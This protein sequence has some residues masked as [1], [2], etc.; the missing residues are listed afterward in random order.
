MDKGRVMSRDIHAIRGRVPLLALAFGASLALAACS[1]GGASSGSAVTNAQ[2]GGGGGNSQCMTAAQDYATFLAGKLPLSASDTNQWDA[3]TTALGNDIGD[4]P[5]DLT[6][7][8]M[9]IFQVESDSTSISSDISQGGAGASDY[10]QF[11]SDLQALAQA[12]GITLKP[13]PKSLTG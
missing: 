3:L 5:S 12:C 4:K 2:G 13:L 6:S 9:T 7:L 1:G 8:G 11:D 10:E